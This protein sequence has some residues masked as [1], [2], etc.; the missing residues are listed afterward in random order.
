MAV[1]VYQTLTV[2]TAFWFEEVSGKRIFRQG[3]ES[4]EWV[5]GLVVEVGWGVGEGGGWRQNSHLFIVVKG[6]MDWAVLKL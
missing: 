1:I 5:W 2:K 3:V 4:R 6:T